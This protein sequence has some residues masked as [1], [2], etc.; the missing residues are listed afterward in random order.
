[1]GS[2]DEGKDRAGD[3]ICGGPGGGPLY[4]LGGA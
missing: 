3:I 4:V 2:M 1:M